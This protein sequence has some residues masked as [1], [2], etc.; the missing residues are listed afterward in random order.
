[1][2]SSNSNHHLCPNSSSQPKTKLSL[3][4][5]ANLVYYV[6]KFT[7]F[8]T[9]VNY[10][11]DMRMESDDENFQNVKIPSYVLFNLYIT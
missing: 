5:L 4:T 2:S 7:D 3:A 11:D 6:S 8:V 10:Q 9:R 1:M